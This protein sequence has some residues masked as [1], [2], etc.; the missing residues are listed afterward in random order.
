M[1]K[2]FLSIHK[3]LTE[4]PIISSHEH[5]LETKQQMKLTLDS[6][7]KNSYV[8]WC[9]LPASTTKDARSQWL[10]SIRSNTYFVWLEKSICQIYGYDEINADNWDSISEDI[11]KRHQDGLHHWH[12]LECYANYKKFIQDSYWNPGDCLSNPEFVAS[13]YRMDTWM[14]GFH[15]N[16][17]DHDRMNPRM[18]V[19]YDMQDLDA[20]EMA[21]KAD[22]ESKMPSICALKCAVAYERDISFKKVSRDKAEKIYGSS[23][24]L[25]SDD[26]RILFGDYIFGYFVDIAR[27]YNIPIQIHTGLARLAGSNPMLLEPVIAANPDVKFVLFHGGFPWFYEVAALAHNYQNVYIDMN[28]LPLV[29]T[30]AAQNAL[31]TF[32]E[33]LPDCRRICWG[34]DCWTSE[35][36]F[37]AAMAFRMVL[38]DVLADKMSSGLYRT[39][40]I[41]FL[42]ERIL[43][44]NCKE[45][46]SMA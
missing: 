13:T 43:F 20:Y 26:D 42:A 30:S 46:Y 32:F 19:D 22:I 14:A 33:V 3:Y 39:S 28:W 31:H 45:L 23:P 36:S 7:F 21:L 35:E 37:G 41:D 16:C 1:N 17:L 8:G 5:H 25:I 29:S 40:Y 11:N 4:L 6:I 27:E 24:E 34:G 9:S 44:Q 38:A 10:T 18:L 12:I 15:K 2:N